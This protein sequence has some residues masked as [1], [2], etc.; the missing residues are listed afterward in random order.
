M[1]QLEKDIKKAI[2]MVK[3]PYED[4]ESMTEY[5]RLYQNTTEN[6]KG[7]M[8]YLNGSYKNALLPTASGDHILETVLYGIKDITCFDINRLAKYFVELKLAAL[9]SL[10]R[11]EYIKFMYDDMFNK[12]YFDYIKNNLD[13]DISIFWSELYKNSFKDYISDNLFRYLRLKKSNSSFYGINFYKYCSENFVSYL[14][15][16]NYTI[17]QNRLQNTNIEYI[18]S[19]LLDLTSKL[20][21]KYDLINL[22]NIYEFINKEIIDN[23]D[24]K[25]NDII[26][27]LISYL[28]DDGKILI[29]YLYK[30]SKKD[31]DM[32]GN[33]DISY[34]KFLY[35]LDN[36][37]I[38]RSIYYKITNKIDNKNII[39]K[40]YA[41]RNVQLLKY[42]KDLNIESYEIE[43][44]GL[45]LSAGDRDM[46][47]ICKK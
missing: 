34:L 35:F 6:I 14:D 44:T 25:F 40:I 13:D 22:T 24:K 1:E 11:E 45:G 36:N 19:D 10:N 5:S 8:P 32:Y 15:K 4:Y 9:K 7:Y 29:T 43:E 17:V 41:F 31:I 3:C 27:N 20:N 2:E 37:P 28:N 46:V 47:L 39:E 18:E 42:M 21:T 12:N 23:G 33:K 38:I 26:R 16:D 30:C